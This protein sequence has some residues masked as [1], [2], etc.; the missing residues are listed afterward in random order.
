MRIEKLKNAGY[1]V[2]IVWESDYKKDKTSIIK[3]CKEFIGV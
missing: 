2:K 3:T 1:S